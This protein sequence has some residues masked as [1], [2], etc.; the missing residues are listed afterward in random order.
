[1][2]SGI[3]LRHLRYFVAV[4]EESSFRRAAARLHISQPPLSRQIG[5]LE[6]RLGVGLFERAGR[7]VGLTEAGRVYL[8]EA[9]LLLARFE[10]G[11]EAARGAGRGEVGRLRIGYEGSSVYDLIPSSV[12]VFRRRFPRVRLSLLEMPGADQAGALREGRLDVGFVV[13]TAGG[14]GGALVFEALLREPLVAVLP[15]GHPLAAGDEVDPGEL[16]GEPF[17]LGPSRPDDALRERVVAVCR[18]AGFAPRVVQEAGEVQAVLGIVAAELGVALL[19]DSVRALGR[20]GVVY[21]PLPPLPEAGLELAMARRRDGASPAARAFADVAKR[22]TR[23][24][25]RKAA[26]RPRTDPPYDS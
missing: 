24:I 16:A 18:G 19:P 11:V 20:E 23:Y 12:R 21:R 4:A 3:E 8:G 6:E 14:D 10:E 7:R 5:A 9:R 17:V 26:R 22:V 25:A 15:G 2:I 1:M 13:P